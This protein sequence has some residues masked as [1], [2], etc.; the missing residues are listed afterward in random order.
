MNEANNRESNA[1][2]PS[3]P[4][5]VLFDVDGVITD[6]AEAHAKAWTRLFDEFLK[7]RS[8]RNGEEQRPFDADHE[9]REIVDGKPRYEGVRSFLQARGIALPEGSKYDSPDTETILGLGNAK[10]GY[11]RD[12]LENNEVHTYPGTIQ[13]IRELKGT[14]VRTGAFSASRNA[15]DVLRNAGVLDLFDAKVDGNDQANMELEGKPNPA[16]LLETASQL[17]IEP[18]RAA[19]VEDAL[20]GVEAGISGGFGVVIGVDRGAYGEALKQAGAHIVVRDLSELVVGDDGSIATKTTDSVPAVFD[21]EEEMRKRLA[22]RTLAV[23]LDYDGTLTPIVEDHTKAFLADDMRDAVQELAN[24]CTVAI[25]S[26]RDLEHIRKLVKVDSVF[27]AGSHGFEIAGP[28]GSTER[29]ERGAKSLP[30]IDEAE[31]RLREGLSDIA[32]HSVERK[33]FSIAVHYRQAAKEDVSRIEA[34]VD[35]VL[36]ECDGLRKGHGKRV[37]RIQPNV[38]WHKGR[39]VLWLLERFQREEHDIFPI[40]IGDDVTDEDAFQ[41]LAGRGFTVVVRDDEPR[42]TAADY[43]VADTA[44]VRRLIDWIG[45]ASSDT[46]KGDGG[47]R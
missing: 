10:Q 5:A 18:G 6:T 44:E 47:D 42:Q 21:C 38:D 20:S 34:V 12:W 46:P 39:A 45:V 23:F 17:G 14:G 15:A 25:V 19:I 31:T 11:F 9:Y 2:T 16:T 4:E 32:G 1:A 29:L 35:E 40:Y 43:S 33:R 28:D 3:Y 22:G 41:A 26:G 37:F 13:F 27:I 36:S 8:E 7:T 30:A 24:G